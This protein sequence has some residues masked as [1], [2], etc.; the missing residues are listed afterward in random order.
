MAVDRAQQLRQAR[1]LFLFARREKI[2]MEEA[3][4]RLAEQRWKDATATL[5]ARRCG[6][7]APSIDPAPE[8]ERT[9][10][11]YNREPFA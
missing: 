11:W 2:T 7:V 9:E 5:A 10:P 4:A 1:E 3:Q 8:G 6:T